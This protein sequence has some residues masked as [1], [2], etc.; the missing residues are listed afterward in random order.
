MITKS[1]N[2]YI[3]HHLCHAIITCDIHN[4]CCLRPF[5][6]IPHWIPSNIMETKIYGVN[7]YEIS[8]NRNQNKNVMMSSLLQCPLN[9][10]DHLITWQQWESMAWCLLRACLWLLI[11]HNAHII[12]FH[13]TIFWPQTKENEPTILWILRFG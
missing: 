6:L 13:V 12:D 2:Q 1:F 4:A 8:E 10:S 7:S 3:P 11:K 5:P 9:S